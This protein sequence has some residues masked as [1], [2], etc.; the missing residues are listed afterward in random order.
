MHINMAASEFTS[1]QLPQALQELVAG[2]QLPPQA[3]CLELT[4][5][6][7]MQRPDQVIPVMRALR[8]QGFGISLDDFGMGHSSLALLRTLPISSLKV[9]RSFVRELATQRNDYAIVKTII[10]LGQLLGLEVIAEGIETVQQR[11]LLIQAG[12]VHMQ[13][14]LF[15]RPLPL[16]SLLARAGTP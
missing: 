13:G 16:E 3:L 10:E 1:D 2:W 9:D 11:E 6:M 4:E 5:G 7:L 12:G 14:Y 8:R 15:D